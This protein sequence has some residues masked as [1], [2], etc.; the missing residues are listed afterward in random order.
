MTARQPS[1]AANGAP[2][3]Q[4]VLHSWCI[5]T[6][7]NAPTVIGG[8][9]ARLF[10]A[11]GR[12]ILDMSSLAE[13]SN[14]GHQHPRVVAAIRAQAQQLCFVTS[15]WGAEPR[16]R[17][18]SLLL[19]EAGWPGGRVFFTLG[20]AD[21]N[22]HAVK[23]AR[24]ASGKPRG[25]VITRE[26]SYHGA[27]YAAMALSGD[28]RTAAQVDP[29][30]FRV[31]RVPPPYAY[32]CPFGT[33]S[34]AECAAAAVRHIEKAIAE[35]GAREVAAV[36]MEPNAGT[37]GIVA[38]DEFWPA[39]RAATHA[40]DTWLIADEVMSAFGRCGEWFAWQR[41]GADARP[42]MM[43]LAKG[44]TGAHLPLGAVVLSAEL[45]R[46]LEPQMLMTGLT[47]CGHP[48]ACAAGVAAIE[49][50]REE[51]LIERSRRL[52]ARMLEELE[53]MQKRHAVIGDVRGGHGL[54]AVAELVSDRLTREPL[55]PWPQQHRSLERLL[56]EAMDRGVS[57]AA[58]GNLLL[59]APPLVISERELAE[60]LA[61]LDELLGELTSNSAGEHRT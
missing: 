34:A 38:P 3:R 11:E 31:L 35:L 25:W 48:L 50:Y 32:R 14:L 61:L 37:N 28:A 41:Y 18:A 47:Y 29:E 45:A 17:L 9:G 39:L 36:M 2:E 42:D 7:W 4:T 8:E 27:S 40:S 43:T 22:E 54:F 33:A 16:A 56:R 57:F 24:A 10:T 5:Q 59:L 30:S 46:A 15:A 52:G 20:G 1:Q 53:R 49:S 13:C 21:A 60:A 6:E 23:F 51:A 55:A 19:D 58:R 12:T 26:R 44:L